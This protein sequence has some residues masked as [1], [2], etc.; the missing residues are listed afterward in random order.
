MVSGLETSPCDQ[1]RMVSGEARL[2]RMASKSAVSELRSAK[3][4][5][6]RCSYASS[7][8]GAASVSPVAAVSEG[9]ADAPS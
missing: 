2:I 6:L 4:D 5:L 8:A 1:D 9:S 7:K 3:V